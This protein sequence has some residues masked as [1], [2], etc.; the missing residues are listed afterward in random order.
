MKE[1]VIRGITIGIITVVCLMMVK[2]MLV[3]VDKPVIGIPKTSGTKYSDA[4]VK[5]GGIPV[6][7]SYDPGKIPEHLETLDGVLFPGGADIPP[8]LYGDEEVHHTVKLV[9]KDRLNFEYQLAEAWLNHTDKPF[10]GVC[11][12][13]QMLNVVKGGT[14][15]QDI[16]SE[17][18]GNHRVDHPIE[19][20][21][22][23]KLHDI[24]KSANI[25]V[26]STHHQAVRELGE[27]LKITARA[28]DGIVEGI[29]MTS[30]RFV[31]GVQW[32]PERLRG[33]KKQQMLFDSFIEAAARGKDA[34]P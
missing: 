24:F 21:P 10:L 4:I 6:M 28:P 33:D 32:H 8:S 18:G 30:D 7:L 34:A 19:V 12:G 22:G 17:F 2:L 14:L 5:A 27:G 1:K 26:N 15:I 20:E 31:V 9:P 25:E 3:K 23:S 29:E 16:P 13:C 11:L